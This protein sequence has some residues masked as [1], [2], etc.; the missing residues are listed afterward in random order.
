MKD[1]LTTQQLADTIGVSPRRVLALAKSRGV[2]SIRV[3]RSHLWPRSAVAAM[4]TRKPGRPRSK[5]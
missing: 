2:R 3:G 5:S 4:K 1:Y